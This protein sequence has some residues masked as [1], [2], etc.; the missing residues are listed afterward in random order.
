MSSQVYLYPI[1]C[2]QH[3]SDP[4]EILNEAQCPHKYTLLVFADSLHFLLHSCF[5]FLT[6]ET[7]D[8]CTILAFSLADSQGRVG[9]LLKTMK[10]QQRIVDVDGLTYSKA[11]VGEYSKR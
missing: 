5:P 8:L 11:F 2:G 10:I 1:G 7:F 9:H 6:D 3:R 4:R